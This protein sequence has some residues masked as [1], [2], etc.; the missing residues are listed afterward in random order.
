MPHQSYTP[1]TP[2][3]PTNP[4]AP[5][6][7]LPSTRPIQ[8]VAHRLATGQP[9]PPN[10]KNRSNATSGG[11][12]WNNNIEAAQVQ[13]PPQERK[14]G[15][16]WNRKTSG[17][18][19]NISDNK[20]WTPV[21]VEPVSERYNTDIAGHL[22]QDREVEQHRKAN[23]QYIRRDR[24]QVREENKR[25]LIEN[26]IDKDIHS[27]EEQ[28][29]SSK[30][31]KNSVAYNPINHAYASGDA[32]KQLQ[33]ADQIERIRL[34]KRGREQY[35]RENSYNPVTGQDLKYFETRVAIDS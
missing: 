8:D 24:A 14:K 17:N 6:A 13:T 3:R 34:E 11:A 20:T 4:R 1:I 9:A 12:L 19:K 25:Y 23:L 35:I 2:Q 18:Q 29:L 30:V 5:P 21:E 16:I 32:G 33:R 7:G 27:I 22:K 31:G 26:E 28:R 15:A 10:R